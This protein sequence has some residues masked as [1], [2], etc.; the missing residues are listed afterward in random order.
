MLIQQQIKRKN[1]YVPIWYQRRFFA[2]DKNALYYLDLDPPKKE[3]SDGRVVIIGREVSAPSPK[4][5]FCLNDLY[6]T[7]FGNTLNDEIERYLFGEIDDKGA[8]AARAFANVDLASIHEYF[9][10][11]A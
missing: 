7:Q 3:L 8:K 6:T 4:S 11:V 5:C 9:G 2:Q 10:F 1:H